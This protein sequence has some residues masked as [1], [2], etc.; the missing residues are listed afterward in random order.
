MPFQDTTLLA[1]EFFMRLPR[2]GPAGHCQF[3][4]VADTLVRSAGLLPSPRAGLATRRKFFLRFDKAEPA[5][6]FQALP[7]GTSMGGRPWRGEV[8]ELVEC[9]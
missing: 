9:T 2:R 3:P 8:A 1:A 4:A 6:G 5:V 7:A